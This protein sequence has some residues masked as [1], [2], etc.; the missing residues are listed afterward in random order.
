MVHDPVA[1]AR[2]H[3]GEVGWGDALR[4]GAIELRGPT[5]AENS[6]TWHRATNRALNRPWR[7]ARQGD[8]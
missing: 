8:P 3:L 7:R 4:S 6:P 1:F 5:S 2:W